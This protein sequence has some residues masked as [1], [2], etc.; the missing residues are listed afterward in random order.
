MK[1]ASHRY[2]FLTPIGIVVGLAASAVAGC[3]SG[4]PATA[5]VAAVER[6]DLTVG[7]VQSVTA[8][9]LYVAAQRGYFKAAGLNVR[10]VPIQGAGPAMPLLLNGTLDI[11]DGNLV[12][13]LSAEAHGA[14][15]LRILAEGYQ[16]GP[17]GFEVV[18]LPSAHVTSVA[19]LRG[20]LIGVNATSDVSQ[21][22]IDAALAAHQ[23]PVSSV[24]FTVIPFPDMATAL[25]AHRIDAA[26]L[27]EPYLTQ[28]R[29]TLGA[30]PVFDSDQGTTRNLPIAG[31]VTTTSWARRYPKTA[32]AF[33]EALDRGQAYANANR[34]A[35][36]Q[37]LLRYTKISSHLI[38]LISVGQYPTATDAGQM[39]RIADLMDTYG[40]LKTRLDT[41][42][43][44]AG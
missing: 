2:R 14:A 35:L 43:M 22:V 15:K 17:H 39:Q 23:V 6:P 30:Q 34:A 1:P 11:T 20:K 5:H 32:A 7:V 18:A 41:S 33:I 3:S 21:L 40:L 31:A 10:I 36:E 13:Y 37:A 27:T 16:A 4:P 38:T 12:S 26:W 9:G 29:A 44:L 28:A 42:Q 25:K 24:R 8:G 19:G